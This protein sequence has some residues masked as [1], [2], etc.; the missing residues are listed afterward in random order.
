M[1]KKKTI[2]EDEDVSQGSIPPTAESLSPSCKRIKGT[3]PMAF[4]IHKKMA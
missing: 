4:G 3:A 1:K 2:R